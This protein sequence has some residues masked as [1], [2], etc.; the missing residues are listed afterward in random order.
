MGTAR[1][2]RFGPGNWQPPLLE[3]EAGGPSHSV[4]FGL[5]TGQQGSPSNSV[6]LLANPGPPGAEMSSRLLLS[7]TGRICSPHP[8][9]KTEEQRRDHQTVI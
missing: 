5:P 7:T 1:F 3:A 6:I 9:M 2:T 8:C 4:P